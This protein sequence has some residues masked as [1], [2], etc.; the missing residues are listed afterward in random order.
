MIPVFICENDPKQMKQLKKIVED[1]IMIEDL[2]M[3]L[4]TADDPHK[5]LEHLEQNKVKNALYFID[6]N[7]SSSINGIA[8]ASLIRK[9]DYLGT[10]VFVTKH[11][12]LMYLTFTYKIEALDFIIKGRFEEM[13]T[14]IQ[15]C[16]RLVYDRTLKMKKSNEVGYQ[17]LYQ[18]KIAGK[19]KL[20]PY[21]EIMFFETSV[22]PHM[23]ILHLTDSKL[24]F[25]G[26]IKGILV[27]NA[28]FRCHK[29]IVV[30][31]NN[32]E[33]IDIS[34]KEALLTNGAICPL[35]TKAVKE[36]KMMKNLPLISNLA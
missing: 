20:I 5:M 12:E 16:I 10:I 13:A 24:E 23:L 22:T 15:E 29:S 32:V 33:S 18:V 27:D 4:F 17:H 8:L 25:R 36:I 6:I 9:L 7:L 3:T 30:N 2:D 26:S 28:F 19:I 35:S 21:E 14:R 34:A 31:L 1:Y 11:P